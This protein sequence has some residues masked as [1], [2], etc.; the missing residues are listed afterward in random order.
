M[1]LIPLIIIIGILFVVIAAAFL[2]VRSARNM[3]LTLVY[4]AP[5]PVTT[6]PDS[7]TMPSAEKN[8]SW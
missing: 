4:P 6:T 5:N 1:K 7:A 3:A 2:L 8:I